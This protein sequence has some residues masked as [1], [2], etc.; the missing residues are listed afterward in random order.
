MSE[1]Q[2]QNHPEKFITDYSSENEYSIYEIKTI[3]KKLNQ[4]FME[5]MERI[6]D[7]LV[8]GNFNLNDLKYLKN[9][10]CEY[11]TLK[12]KKTDIKEH[13]LAL[14]NSILSATLCDAYNKSFSFFAN[15]SVFDWFDRLQV[16]RTQIIMMD[17]DTS[18]LLSCLNTVY[19]S[20]FKLNFDF[21]KEFI[22]EDEGDIIEAMFP[23][24]F[25][26]DKV[27]DQLVEVDDLNKR[28]KILVNAIADKDLLCLKNYE[29]PQTYVHNIFFKKNCIDAIDVLDNQ[30]KLLQDNNQ[31]IKKVVAD[32]PDNKN[33]SKNNEEEQLVKSNEFSTR[34]Q[35][36]AMY[37][38]LNEV[39]R[40]TI[41]I[42]RTVKVR[43]IHFLTQKNESN[44]Y[45]SLSEPHKGL[46]NDKNKKSAIRDLEYIK[47]HFD[48]LGLK[49][50]S[51][52][53]MKD[54][55]EA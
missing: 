29:N 3:Y 19:N 48:D 2:N 4:N 46:E 51:Q 35:V 40:N 6:E 13:G 33:S 39:D 14:F 47:K 16:Y 8:T 25:D 9:R 24:E 22:E 27:Y 15:K 37:Y 52:K 17:G 31:Q 10:N 38:L 45:K 21:T 36:L 42:D 28:K 41:A 32:V 1:V 18:F 53:I 26:F 5:V 49:S 23:L 55:Q 30:I 50:I 43:F 44:I 20:L 12:L 7:I 11:K 54:M 34:R